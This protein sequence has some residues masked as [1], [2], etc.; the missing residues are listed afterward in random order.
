MLVFLNAAILAFSGGGSENGGL[1]SVSGGLMIWTAVT[2]LVLLFVLTKLAWKPILNSLGEREKFIKDSLENAEKAQKEAERL[3][4]ENNERLAKS[5]EEAQ[6]IIAQGREY[7]DK[8][9]NQ[10]LEESKSNAK[11]MIEDASSE[12]ER[13]NQEAFTNLKEQVVDI[14]IQAAEKI[15]R[16]DLDK[17]KQSKLVN[18]YLEDLSK[19]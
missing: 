13:K 4:E 16:E 7:A 12:I 2:F 19:N 18:K 14:A 11:K 9:K 17:E 3:M 5:E 6:K 15:I 10:I 1:L 8:L